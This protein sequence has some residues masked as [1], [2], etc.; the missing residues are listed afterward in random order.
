MAKL[1]MVQLDQ[2]E[3][4]FTASVVVRNR[5]RAEARKPRIFI[6][7][8]KNRELDAKGPEVLAP[9]GIAEYE[10][11]IPPNTLPGGSR[12]VL[13]NNLWITCENCG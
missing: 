3:E 6:K 7:S 9:Q 2:P 10:I 11:Y 1:V 4:S 13:W 8:L 12:T 5:G